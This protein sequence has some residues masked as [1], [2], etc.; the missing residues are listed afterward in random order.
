M[1]MFN[2]RLT[3]RRKGYLLIFAFS[4]FRNFKWPLSKILLWISR[5]LSNFYSI[6]QIFFDLHIVDKETAALLNFF[7]MCT[8]MHFLSLFFLNEKNIATSLLR[9]ITISLLMVHLKCTVV[10][11]A[12]LNSSSINKLFLNYRPLNI[13]FRF[14]RFLIY[15]YFMKLLSKNLW[16]NYHFQ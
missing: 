2:W 11:Y 9:N 16:N 5:V 14:F 4:L 8:D 7:E 1:K 10:H 13:L 15:V 3:G 12:N 6:S